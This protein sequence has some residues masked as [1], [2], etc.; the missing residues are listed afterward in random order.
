[1]T[2][3]VL[4][5]HRS[6]T[7]MIAR[8]LNLCG[9]HL[10]NPEDIMEPHTLDNPDGYW[11]N[12]RIVA[13]ND[14]ILKGFGGTDQWPPGL[15]DGWTANPILGETRANAKDLIAEMSEQP[16]WGWKDPRTMLTLPFWQNLIP[17]D[18]KYVLI[19]RNPLEVAMSLGKRQDY[20]DAYY[21]PNLS[22]SLYL[23]T[24][25]HLKALEAMPSDTIV[26]SYEAF[27]SNPEPELRRVL[28][29]LGLSP[30]DE[31]IAEAAKHINPELRRNKID[32][33]FLQEDFVAE[34]TRSIYRDLERRAGVPDAS[35][36]LD[37]LPTYRKLLGL[38]LKQM[39]V[40]SQFV[41][42]TR[43]ISIETQKDNRK[44]VDGIEKQMREAARLRQQLETQ[45][46]MRKDVEKKIRELQLVRRDLQTQ[47]NE[48]SQQVSALREELA[49]EAALKEQLIAT[50]HKELHDLAHILRYRPFYERLLNRLR[51]R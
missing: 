47:V 31:T 35:E 30:S 13:I 49:R 48:K 9:M 43:Q 38:A 20:V 5:M 45:I 26:C 12:T 28:D 24:E 11:E 3:C 40:Q 50:H 8:L 1:M 15:I 4:G 10:G 18:L 46:G 23:W 21:A 27:F 17:T 41:K 39:S 16:V 32:G 7:S 37:A 36:K 6:G 42:G 29:A 22:H 33:G 19:Y 44:L 25:Y 34:E 2:I 14:S 51:S